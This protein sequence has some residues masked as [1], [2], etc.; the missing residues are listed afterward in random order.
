VYCR[1]QH[2][3]A[4]SP[5]KDF[6][7]ASQPSNPRSGHVASTCGDAD[8]SRAMF[9]DARFVAFS[10]WQGCRIRRKRFHTEGEGDAFEA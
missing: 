4:I 5:K 9:Q 6:G 7:P 1:K 10:E 3:K 8:L 2:S